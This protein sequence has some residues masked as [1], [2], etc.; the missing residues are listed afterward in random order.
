MQRF[1]RYPPDVTVDQRN[2]M[3]F[4][5][6]RNNCSYWLN[7]KNRR[8]KCQGKKQ[9]DLQADLRQEVTTL[10]SKPRNDN[11]LGAFTSHS[12]F[13]P[14]TPIRQPAQVLLVKSVLWLDHW[15]LGTW[16]LPKALWSEHQGPWSCSLI[17]P[18]FNFFI[19][20]IRIWIWYSLPVWKYNP[21][22]TN[23]FHRNAFLGVAIS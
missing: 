23:K 12:H 4:G 13:T 5:S 11:P 7:S 18:V 21:C 22:F 16:V 1:F 9:V 2:V 14:Q 19:F 8:G 3:N 17:N 10:H 20:K 6:E 15:K